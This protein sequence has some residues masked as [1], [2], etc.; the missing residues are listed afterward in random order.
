[1]T[2]NF[3]RIFRERRSPL[4]ER[5]SPGR[6]GDRTGFADGTPDYAQDSWPTG[7][8][9]SASTE[10]PGPEAERTGRGRR[11]SAAGRF[12]SSTRPR[13]E[14]FGDADGNET[15]RTGNRPSPFL[16]P[17]SE[18]RSLEAFIRIQR[19]S[20]GRNRRESAQPRPK[21]HALESLRRL[22]IEAPPPCVPARMKPSRRLKR[23]VPGLGAAFRGRFA[24]F[25]GRPA[26]P[27][28]AAATL[29]CGD[30]SCRGGH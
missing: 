25:P 27:G 15:G 29:P 21:R 13:A 24:R 23:S 5:F 8:G 28:A 1:M 6:L 2:Q 30:P 17:A 14:R 9:G 4:G 20:R 26:I 10:I 22:R 11:R 19:R 7:A 18:K 3:P 16:H 12:R